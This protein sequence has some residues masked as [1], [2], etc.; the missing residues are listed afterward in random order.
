[1]RELDASSQQLLA[2]KTEL[3]QKLEEQL[4]SSVNLER[5]LEEQ[6]VAK[7]KLEE[8]LEEQLAAKRQLTKELAHEQ[9]RSET[10]AN[11]VFEAEEQ[12][13]ILTEELAV[14]KRRLEQAEK[15]LE[16]EQFKAKDL[17]VSWN[18]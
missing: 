11:K 4:S 9:K 16:L 7:L 10:E 18:S 8:Q 17:Q 12:A 5:Q 2:A 6:L 14:A 1:M 15:Q 13:M 3:E